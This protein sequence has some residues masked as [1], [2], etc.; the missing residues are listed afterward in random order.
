VTE[1]G[2]GNPQTPTGATTTPVVTR[3]RRH[4][5]VTVD[6][7]SI[8]G[9]V[10]A[11]VAALFVF[12]IVRPAA[13]GLTHLAIGVLLGLALFPLVVRVREKLQCRHTVAVAIVGGMVLLFAVLVGMVMGPPA[14]NQAEKFGRQ[15]PETVQGLYDLPIVGPRL[16]KADAAHK[17]DK[18]VKDLPARIDSQTV[19]DVTRSL[20]TGAVALVTVV[21]IALAVLLDGEI[22]VGRARRLLP[23]RARSRADE[24]ARIFYRVIGKYFAGSLVVAVL[25]GVYI[26]AVGLAFGVPLAP[27]AAMWMVLTD[28]IPQIGGFLGGAFFTILAVSQSVT[29][30]VICLVLYLIYMNLE[31]HVISPAIVGEAVD[32]SPPTTMLAALVGGAA[33]GIPGALFATPLAGAIKQLYLEFRFGHNTLD[34]KPRRRPIRNLLRRRREN[35]VT[36]P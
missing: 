27:I 22:L 17:V 35:T 6:P 31:N 1:A 14:V 7:V 11:V 33:A 20:L 25:A 18:W 13:T 16:E 19:S 34:D 32:L 5:V 26:L 8:A 29:V 23:D 3:R 28:L 2:S 24:I 30:G 4:F 12:P 21:L 9:V 36:P 10:V 15:L